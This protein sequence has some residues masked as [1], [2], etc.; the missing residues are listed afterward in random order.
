MT[1]KFYTSL[2]ESLEAFEPELPTKIEDSSIVQNIHNSKWFVTDRRVMRHNIQQDFSLGI[3]NPLSFAMIYSNQDSS[4]Q[5][6]V[7]QWP[8]HFFIG[9]K[10]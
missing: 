10:N 3:N 6:W 7:K 4:E 9:F 1:F 2:E 5:P 8:R